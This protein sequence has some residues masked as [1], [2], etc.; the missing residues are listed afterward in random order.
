MP[1][2]KSPFLGMKLS[3]QVVPARDQRL[4]GDTTRQPANQLDSQEVEKPNSQPA[5]RRE[6]Q[7]ANLPDVQP[8]NNLASRDLSTLASQTASQLASQPA[9]KSKSQRQNFPKRTYHLREETITQL[10]DMQMA[11]KRKYGVK[12]PLMEEI[13]ELAITSIYEDFEANKQTSKLVS[14]LKS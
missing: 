2:K 11:L 14:K 8:D 1:E 4:F 5:S 9:S 3:D 10:E 7:Q 13:V 12:R 6:G